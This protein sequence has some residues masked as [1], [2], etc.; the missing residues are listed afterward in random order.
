[1]DIISINFRHPANEDIIEYLRINSGRDNA[2][3]EENP[4]KFDREWYEGLGT[5]PELVELLW[6][7]NTKLIPVDC[8]WVMWARPVLVHPA[9]GIVFAFAGGTNL[10][11]FRLPPEEHFNAHLAKQK[12]FEG[13]T[14]LDPVFALEG[15][16]PQWA[17]FYWYKDTQYQCLQAYNYAETL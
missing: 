13:R 7:N 6:Y 17:S 4:D 8:R 16:Y 1:M 9:T 5:H 12:W 10:Y 11:G 2:P 14:K 15:L 3:F